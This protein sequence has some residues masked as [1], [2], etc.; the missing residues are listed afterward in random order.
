KCLESIHGH[1]NSELVMYIGDHE[2]DTKFARNLQLELGDKTKII[3]VA[4]AYSRSNPES[5]A[6]KPDY[7]AHNVKDLLSIIGKYA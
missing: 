6:V 4:A 5:W 1:T 3:S 7:V 2:A